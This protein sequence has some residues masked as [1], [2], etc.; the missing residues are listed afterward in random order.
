MTTGTVLLVDDEP[1]IRETLRRALRDDGHAVTETGDPREALRMASQQ[2]FDVVVVDHVMPGLNGVEVI[3][4]LAKTTTPEER[5]QLV[6]MT[7]YASVEHAVEAM[8][9]GAFEYL[10]KPFD[11][12]AFL[13]VV[14]RAIELQRLRGHQRLLRDE[15][16]E[17]FHHYGIVGRSGAMLDVVRTARTVAESKSTVLITGETGTGKELVARAIHEWSKQRDMPLVRVNCAALPDTLIESELFGHVRGAFTGAVASKR[18]RFALADGGTIFLDEVATIAPAAQAK[19][20]RVLQEREFEPLGAER[21]VK[22]DVRIIAATNRDLRKLVADGLFLEDLF[23]RLNVIPIHVPP[24]RER[25]EDIPPLVDH[26]IRAHASRAGK[27]ITGITPAALELVSSAPW[28]G[29][30]RELENAVERAVVLTRHA[31]VQLDDIAPAVP[32][33]PSG[34]LPTLLLKA[35]LDY[36]ERETVRQALAR[37]GGVKKDAAE[38]MGISQ[39]AL[40]YYLAKHRLE[41]DS[42]G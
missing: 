17:H 29:N 30:V 42:N 32:M 8:K 2:P 9:L 10:Q 38:I 20:L 39:R 37:T 25:R 6:M 31:L 5:P 3:Q 40:S 14:R 34:Q 41:P 24:L 28:P 21:T 22:V 35:N 1:K 12:D 23:Y 18:G 15:Q 16:A 19:L 4:H 27:R 33:R 36:I 11:I 7:A 26:F 13:V